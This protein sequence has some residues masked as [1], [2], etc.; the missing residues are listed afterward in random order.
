MSK[1]IGR[2]E[3]KVR[4]DGNFLTFLTSIRIDALHDRS[5]SITNRNEY[6]FYFIVKKCVPLSLAVLTTMMPMLIAT[7]ATSNRVVTFYGKLKLL[8]KLN[9]TFKC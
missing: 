2:N 8:L 3:F 6:N 1:G 9:K 5:F 7:R 4:I